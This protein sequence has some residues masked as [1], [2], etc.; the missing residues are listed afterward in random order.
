MA[1][2][3]RALPTQHRANRAASSSACDA[4]PAQSKYCP[5]SVQAPMTVKN[6]S[7]GLH[8]TGRTRQSALTFELVVHEAPADVVEQQADRVEPDSQ[9]C[10]MSQRRKGSNQVGTVCQ[11]SRGVARTCVRQCGRYPAPR[12]LPQA[13]VAKPGVPQ[14]TRSLSPGPSSSCVSRSHQFF[15]V[16]SMEDTSTSRCAPTSLHTAAARSTP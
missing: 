7:P 8:R 3:S 10:S 5:V 13:V 16:T 11:C 1:L 14:P 6:T 15:F 9:V 12:Y 4:P 2:A